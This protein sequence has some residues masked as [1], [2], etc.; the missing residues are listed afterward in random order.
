MRTTAF[1]LPRLLA[2]IEKARWSALLTAPLEI[3]DRQPSKRLGA[4]DVAALLELG[5]H[6][7]L[8]LRLDESPFWQEL[9]KRITSQ[10]N[11]ADF[12]L[13]G[14]TAEVAAEAAGGRVFRFGAAH[15]D[16]TPWNRAPQHTP[17]CD[18]LALWD[19]ES[20]REDAP[21]GY[22]AYHFLTQSWLLTGAPSPFADSLS[23]RFV[24]AL[25]VDAGA[26]ASDWALCYALYLLDRLSRPEP[27]AGTRLRNLLLTA[28]FAVAETI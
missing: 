3:G 5:R 17:R 22:D 25:L 16:Y 4:R 1:R 10:P 11:R 19:W 15:G 12:R 13:L 28:R 8:R 6:R 20:Y 23:L 26:R 21:P 18:R 14:R 27:R 2:R 9:R 24:E 7:G